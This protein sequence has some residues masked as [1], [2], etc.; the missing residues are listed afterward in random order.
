[1][2][3]VTVPFSIIFTGLILFTSMPLVFLGINGKPLFGDPGNSLEQYVCAVGWIHWFMQLAGNMLMFPLA[4]FVIFKRTRFCLNQYFELLVPSTVI[5]ARN[6]D[7]IQLENLFTRL[8]P[9]QPTPRNVLMWNKGRR[10]IQRYGIFYR[11]RAEV[12]TALYIVIVIIFAVYQIV[13]IFVSTNVGI[14]ESMVIITTIALLV[15]I[16]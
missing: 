3:S 7:P 5:D 8:P 10:A 14:S 6:Y 15:T 9:M 13:A 1:M 16:A 12:F 2:G 11:R 4:P